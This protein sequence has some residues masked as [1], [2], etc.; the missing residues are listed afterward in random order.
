M[1]PA[2]R[3][4]LLLTAI[5]ASV[6]APVAAPAAAE[7]PLSSIDSLDVSVSGNTITAEGVATIADASDAIVGTD[8]TGDA[9]LNPI[10]G[11]PVS[12]AGLGMD[13]TTAGIR[14]DA[15]GNRLLFTLGIADPIEQTFTIPE[16]V[17]YHWLI[18]VTNGDTS[19]Y[20][21]LQAMRSGQYERTLPSADP[22]FRVN[23]CG[24]LASGNP[25]CFEV[26]GHVE[27]VMSDGIVQWNI[28]V[29]LIGAYD[30]AT[31]EQSASDQVRSIFSAS[32]AA[33]V[34]GHG[35]TIETVP[36][37]VAPSVHMGIRK[38]TQDPSLTLYPTLAA[39]GPDGSFV[40]KLTTPKTPGTYVVSARA[41]NGHAGGCATRD[42][43]VVV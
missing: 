42:V 5:F 27:G 7:G 3:V 13:L 30:G 1:H 4:S 18:K 40:G 24:S 6:A 39:L 10:V 37:V 12:L 22:L 23:S 20:Y 2:L 28:P 9:R 16:L 11:D 29:A 21:Q 33:Y 35:D 31:I 41:C 14:H 32:G 17:G 26:A 15:A 8:A 25:S 19:I 43:Q 36:Y 34:G 38:T